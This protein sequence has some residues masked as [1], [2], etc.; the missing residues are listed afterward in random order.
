MSCDI[1]EKTTR[2]IQK[3]NYNLS[4]ELLKKICDVQEVKMSDVLSAIGE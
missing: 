4:V 2:L 1:D 3:E